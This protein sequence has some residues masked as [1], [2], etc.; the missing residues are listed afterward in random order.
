M[1]HRGIA[2]TSRRLPTA[3]VRVPA[4]RSLLPIVVETSLRLQIPTR[5]KQLARFVAP[6]FTRSAK[7]IRFLL[8]SASADSG[9]SP[10]LAVALHQM[11]RATSLRLQI[12]TRAKQL[13]RFV[14]PRFTRSA[15]G[16]RT[17]VPWLRTMCPGPG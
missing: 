17:P 13:A 6:R 15:K 10:G 16:I 7:G 14:A 2:F 5:A 8:S 4:S 9:S 11:L 1:V 12:P 3:L